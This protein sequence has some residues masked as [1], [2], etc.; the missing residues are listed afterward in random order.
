MTTLNVGDRFGKLVLLEKEV[1]ILPGNAWKK[2]VYRTYWHCKC[3]CGGETTAIQSNIA[4]GLTKSCHGCKSGKVKP[5]MKFGRLTVIEPGE[6]EYFWNCICECGN[7]TSTYA[8]Q[9][10][11]GT[12]KSCGC[13]SHELIAEKS[14]KHGHDKRGETTKT[15]W[16]WQAMIQRCTNENREDYKNYG[17]RG[18]KVCDR[19]LNS[20]EDF[21]ADV[22]ES[23][24]GL[25]IDR[26]NN[27]GNYE[28]GNTRWATREQQQS[29][30]R[31]S[32]KPDKE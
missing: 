27:D 13:L 12:T 14:F 21:L 30:T 25:S 5:G 24:E 17:G 8:Y 9:L 29:N 32:L 20:F 16:C 7:K 3:D 31:R 23:P 26:I 4:R 11:D 6:K 22:G 2:N 18:I 19:W 10:V 28:P 15:Y 1:K